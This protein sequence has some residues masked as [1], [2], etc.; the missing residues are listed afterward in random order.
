MH[1]TLHLRYC[2]CLLVQE[3]S[4]NKKYAKPG[5]THALPAVDSTATRSFW[6]ASLLTR[7]KSWVV[8]HVLPLYARWSSQQSTPSV[9][10]HINFIILIRMVPPGSQVY[11]IERIERNVDNTT[12]FVQSHAYMF[13]L[14]TT[15]WLMPLSPLANIFLR[16]YVY[17]RLN[18]VYLVL[19][20]TNPHL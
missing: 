11:C 2:H 18:G 12:H 9:Q 16:M 5:S 17:L 13:F 20:R 15:C 19:H 3:P 4:A 6:Y 14:N 7:H 8:C 10:L 1:E